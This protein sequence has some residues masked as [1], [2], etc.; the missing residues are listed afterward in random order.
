[1]GGWIHSVFDRAVNIMTAGGI[2]SILPAEKGLYPWSC[3][4]ET[5]VP[6]TG[7][8]LKPG[9]QARITRTELQVIDAGFTVDFNNT[10]VKNLD[11]FGRASYKSPEQSCLPTL[12]ALLLAEGNLDGMLPLALNTVDNP[13]SFMIR[14]RLTALH[15]AFSAMDMEK[16]ASAAAAIAG[17]GI[18]L[19]PSSDDMLLG[20]VYTYYPLAEAKGFKRADALAIG[21]SACYAAAKKTNDISGNFLLRCG[22]GL[23]SQFMSDLLN[24]LFSGAPPNRLK[25][26]VTRILRI[27]SASG[28]DILCGIVLSMKIHGGACFG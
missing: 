16:A 6:F 14:P 21:Q 22:D 26:P 28:S 27:G 9:M 1:M 24:V 17:L 15:A 18:G 23:I 13:F 2:I 5:D 20:Y 11:V 19:T 3:T 12:K 8:G 7:L 4:V 10:I 25:L